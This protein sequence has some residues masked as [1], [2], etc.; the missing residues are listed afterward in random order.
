MTYPPKGPCITCGKD[1]ESHRISGNGRV[2]YIAKG[3]YQG[4]ERVAMICYKCLEGLARWTD[5]H[6]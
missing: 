1:V 4:Y 5:E 3:G 6:Q 2:L